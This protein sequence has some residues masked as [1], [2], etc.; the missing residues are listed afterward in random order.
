MTQHDPTNAPPIAD[1]RGGDDQYDAQ[2]ELLRAT[3][4]LV[5]QIA[6]LEADEAQRDYGLALSRA[7]QGQTSEDAILALAMQS[8]TTHLDLCHAHA[9]TD[10]VELASVANTRSMTGGL[11]HYPFL[12]N[13]KVVLAF[14]FI[15]CAPAPWSEADLAA[16]EATAR[17]LWAAL[18]AARHSHHHTTQAP[19]RYTS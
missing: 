14:T 6:L 1:M 9:I 16:T 7:L 18:R 8:L 17:T 15:K 11:L 10:P 13:G 4:Q 12:Q 5:R 2:R 19:A 3:E